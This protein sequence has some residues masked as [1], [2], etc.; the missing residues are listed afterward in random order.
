MI[1][2]LIVALQ[3]VEVLTHVPPDRMQSKNMFH[4]NLTKLLS[5]TSSFQ[6]IQELEEQ[7]K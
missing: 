1:M 7:V 3:M 6:D 4:L 5:I 2:W